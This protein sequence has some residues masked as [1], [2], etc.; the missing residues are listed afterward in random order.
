MRSSVSVTPS[1]R[2]KRP[3]AGA[4]ISPSRTSLS[5]GA[6]PA[7]SPAVLRERGRSVSPSVKKGIRP[8]IADD[9]A[10]VHKGSVAAYPNAG[11]ATSSTASPSV[12]GGS[13]SH[14]AQDGRRLEPNTCETTFS[15]HGQYEHIAVA[16]RTATLWCAN[17][18]TGAMDL[19]SC[20]TGQ[21][22]T[23][24]LPLHEE[25]VARRAEL[26]ELPLSAP[27][28][29]GTN[30]SAKGATGGLL[31]SHWGSTA[32]T[33]RS[34]G[35]VPTGGGRRL[36]TLSS[37]SATA[38]HHRTASNSL[39]ASSLA[40]AWARV[41]EGDLR[42]TALCATATHMWVGY[43]NGTVAVYDAL[44]LKL[45]TFGRL[46]T[47]R[48]VSIVALFNGQ[49][50][51]ASTDGLLILWDTEQGGFE[52][53]TRVTVLL[54]AVR[55]GAGA[56]C[57]MASISPAT[58]VC[59]G[60][61][62]GVIY[63]VR[64]ASRPQEQTAPQSV[65]GHHGR[66]N[67]M[68]VVR[69]VL[70]TAAEDNT[71][72]A[73]HCGGAAGARG[74]QRLDG[75]DGG[76]SAPSNPFLRAARDAGH[77]R[78]GP[79]MDGSVRM[80]KRIPVRPCVRCLL[81][82]EQTRSVWVAYAD[83][84]VERWSANPDDDY[85]VEEVVEN[86]LAASLSA[87]NGGVRALLSLSVVQTM[88]WLALS[89][90]GVNK[91]WYGHR[92]TL[93]IDLA[94]SISTLAQ[95]VE[96]DTVDAAA[97]RE[98]VNLLKQKE[99]E[100]KQKYVCILEQLSEQR[101]LL[102]HY[103]MW[104]RSVLFFG[105]RRRRVAAIADTLEKKSRLQLARRFFNKWGSFYDAQQRH[106]RVYVLSMALSRATEQQQLQGYFLRW[107]SYLVHRQVRR[108]AAKSA[109][110]L[111]RMV[112][113][114]IMGSCFHRWRAAAA[115]TTRRQRDRI[116][117]EQ[118]ALLANKAQRQVL[119]RVLRQWVA[120]HDT[121]KTLPRQVP[122]A[123][124][125]G[126]PRDGLPVPETSALS[127]FAAHYAQQQQQRRGRQALQVWRR[128]T[129]WRARQ[130]S[131]AAVAAL[132]EQ[133]LLHEARQRFFL[134][135]RQRV[136]ARHVDENTQQLKMLEV[137]LRRAEAEH[138][139]IFE[140]LQLQRQLDLVLERQSAEEAR[141][142]QI[143]EQLASAEHTCSELRARQL[144]RTIVGSNGAA[145]AGS[146]G[147]SLTTS[148][149]AATGA[150]AAVAPADASRRS[151]VARFAGTDTDLSLS[152]TSEGLPL[153][154]QQQQ[155]QVVLSAL[156]RGHMASNAAWYRSMVDQ[157]RLSPIVLS[158]MPTEEAVHHVMGQLKGN[159]VNLY[160]DLALFRQVKDRRRAGTSAVGILLEAFGEVKRL[161]VT[162][163]RGTS[164][165]AASAA[166]ARMGGKATRWP[167]SMEA[168]DCIPVHHCATV[169]SAIKTLVVAYDL[170]Q[171]EDMI[172]VQTTCE[173][174]V[175]NAD[176][177]FLIAR[178]CYLRRKPVPP[179][180]NRQLI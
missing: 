28:A 100:R 166:A 174:V 75:G 40:S 96:Q 41:P 115:A 45:V 90:N 157:Q 133:Q 4:S 16:H 88:Q 14:F 171:P 173:E 54:D 103:D 84:L 65:R 107:Q 122:T 92:N 95:V 69:D 71:V 9:A 153:A 179:A 135:W 167:L 139:D 81:A 163:V 138:G 74:A 64:I 128:W 20:V 154:Q 108:K 15:F 177:I 58:R 125:E 33:P 143:K 149:G 52:A 5:R 91:V 170:L 72:C 44:L 160:T 47:D 117:A 23:S 131:L 158:H 119:Q 30:G 120:H 165:N 63:N 2:P 124:A 78:F 111:A 123:A 82:E 76:G 156:S 129:R 113:A 53:V 169:L 37:T 109:Q 60:F 67:D 118:L 150:S 35:L 38:H 57:A 29:K 7:K 141:L 25:V 39:S 59:C 66:V 56:L 1:R 50:V 89:S 146:C 155:Q 31:G 18:A 73:W 36:S 24:L 11:H 144:Q 112:N 79:H 8:G 99:L 180:N 83:G 55:E 132:R 130:A 94:H 140:K 86:A 168:L 87:G 134:R 26:S 22:V 6:S 32:L 116:S 12:T 21:F 27:S 61:E 114:A 77:A 151:S 152:T 85:G 127:R 102:R 172:S 34:R 93:E 10:A 68:A 13:L 105:T 43:T 121:Q 147:S 98:R 159:V 104:K 3:N 19:Y 49:T 46:H 80:L 178:A 136:H 97:W 51:S 48:I 164:A 17:T 42:A 162:T 148:S 176:W 70:F 137:E 142:A 175:V 110:V 101:V 126:A 106:M 161:I 62:S 145:H